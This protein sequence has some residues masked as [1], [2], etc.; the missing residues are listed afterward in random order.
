[1]MSVNTAKEL[2]YDHPKVLNEVD[3]FGLTFVHWAV[4][5]NDL[6]LVQFLIEK[7]AN[8]FKKSEKNESCLDVAKRMNFIRIMDYLTRRVP[9]V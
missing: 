5:S 3:S 6:P 8:P 2:L 7:G 9:E 1:M 4:M